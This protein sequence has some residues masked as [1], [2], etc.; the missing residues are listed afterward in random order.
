VIST[1]RPQ[2]RASRLAWR[3]TIF[4]TPVPTVPSPAMPRRQ[5]RSW[6]ASG[7]S[8]LASAPVSGSRRGLQR[9]PA[10]DWL[11]EASREARRRGGAGRRCAPRGSGPRTRQCAA[12]ACRHRPGSGPRGTSSGKSA[13]RA[14]GLSRA[15]SAG[16]SGPQAASRGTAR[17]QMRSGRPMPELTAGRGRCPDVPGGRGGMVELNVCSDNLGPWRANRAVT[18]ISPGRR[19]GRRRCGCSRGTGSPPSRC[20][21]SRARWACRRGRCISTRPTS[22]RF[23]SN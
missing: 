6:E 23:C 21:R 12:A 1:G 2:R 8:N 18:A 16:T 14:S 5:G 7:G 11:R 4:T 13:A 15:S 3:W 10:T 17:R 9:G 20:A 22:R 19:S